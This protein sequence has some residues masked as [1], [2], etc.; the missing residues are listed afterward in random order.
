MKQAKFKATKQNL[1]ITFQKQDARKLQF[2][3]EFELVIMICEGAF[4]LM[5][6][7]EMNF[8]IL[9]NASNALKS[10]GKLIFLR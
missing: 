6:T 9:K 10:K 5:E 3:N 8:Q 4:P 1:K 7:D 2:R